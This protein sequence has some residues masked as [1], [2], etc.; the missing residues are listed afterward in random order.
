MPKSRIVALVLL[1]VMSVIIASFTALFI[2]SELSFKGIYIQ[3]APVLEKIILPDIAAQVIFCIFTR[4]QMPRSSG[5]AKRCT[6]S[7]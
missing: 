1:D 6:R 4:N 5:P 3:F 7:L 2:R